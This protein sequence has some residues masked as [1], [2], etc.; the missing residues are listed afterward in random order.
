[1]FGENLFSINRVSLRNSLDNLGNPGVHV[2][3]E[4]F[5]DWVSSEDEVLDFGKHSKFVQFIPGLYSVVTKEEIFQLLTVLKS[6]DFVDLVIGKPEFFKSL[7]DFIE[8]HDSLN[9]V[10]SQRQNFDVLQFREGSHAFNCIG[11]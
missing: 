4:C 7:T 6:V 11:G 5:L 2:F 9:V 3:C 1:M 8:C 10:A